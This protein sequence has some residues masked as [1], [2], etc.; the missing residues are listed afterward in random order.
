MQDDSE[1]VE[2]AL[3]GDQDAFQDL[4]LRYQNKVLNLLTRMLRDR[5]NAQDLAQEVFLKAYRKLDRLKDIRKFGSWIMQ[6]AHNRGLDF[7]KKRRPDAVLTDFQDSRTELMVSD[8][9]EPKGS[10]NPAAIVERM[11]NPEV[12]QVLEELDLKYRTIL[13]LRFLEDYPFQKIAD[14]LD[15]PLST[16]KFRKFYAMKMMKRRILERRQ[17]S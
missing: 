17:Q 4:I 3:A 12:M 14:I 8:F 11:G 10:E 13:I 5:Q 1:L 2:A 9:V 7:I 16:V 15:L 6:M